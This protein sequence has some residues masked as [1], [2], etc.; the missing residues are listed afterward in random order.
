MLFYLIALDTQYH[1]LERILV[2]EQEYVS[3]RAALESRWKDYPTF[4]HV[5]TQAKG[6]D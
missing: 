3:A 2:A 1:E 4:S 5:A 6:D